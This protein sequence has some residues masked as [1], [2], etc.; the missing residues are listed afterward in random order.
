ML[1]GRL[2]AALL[3]TLAPAETSLDFSRINA[4][5]HAGGNKHSKHTGAQDK[6]AALKRKNKLRIK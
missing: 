1:T 6:R 4:S 3:S 5:G 2:V